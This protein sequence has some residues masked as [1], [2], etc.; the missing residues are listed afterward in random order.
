MDANVGWQYCYVCIFSRFYNKSHVKP[1]NIQ[2][3][4]ARGFCMPLFFKLPTANPN[5]PNNRRCAV[6]RDVVLTCVYDIKLTLSCTHTRTRTRS[7]R[8]FY[9]REASLTCFKH[10]RCHNRLNIYSCAVGN[11]KHGHEIFIRCLN[12]CVLFVLILGLKAVREAFLFPFY[13]LPSSANGLS[14]SWDFD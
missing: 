9:S 13:E 8:I 10:T 5:N 7:T 3:F 2:R 11:T 4:N 12:R 6:A 14:P 1:S